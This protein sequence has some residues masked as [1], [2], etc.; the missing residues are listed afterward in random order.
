MNMVFH[1]KPRKRWRLPC[2]PMK[3][4]TGG[5]AICRQLVTLMGGDMGLESLEGKGSSFWFTAPL[6]KQHVAINVLPS[7]A[8]SAGRPGNS[9]L[10]GNVLPL[11]LAED[12]PTSQK[13]VRVFLTKLGYTVDVAG[14]G[15]EV[16][17]ALQEKEYSLVLMDGMMPGMNGYEAA[18]VIR[19]QG[20]SVRNHDIPIVALTANAMHADR[21]K[22]LAAG[23]DDYLAKP[24][25]FVALVAMLEKWLGIKGAQC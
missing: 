17:K 6:K 18:A 24:L 1:L 19:D 23:M 15:H 20:S 7:S 25:E 4:G 13:L 5:L 21:E 16:L 11:L 9:G 2:W 10:T 8:T 12:D 22:C 3:H 14:N